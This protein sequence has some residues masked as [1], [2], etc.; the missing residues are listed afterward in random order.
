[1]AILL[2]SFLRRSLVVPQAES[3]SRRL[4]V[5]PPDYSPFRN[6]IRWACAGINVNQAEKI[7]L[8]CNKR[9]RVLDSILIDRVINVLGQVESLQNARD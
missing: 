1:M 2:P 7:A 4:G 3:K 9:Y 5:R 8:R 6:A